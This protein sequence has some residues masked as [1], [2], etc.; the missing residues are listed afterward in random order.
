MHVSSRVAVAALATASLTLSLAPGALASSGGAGDRPQRPWHRNLTTDVLFPFQLAVHASHVWVADGATKTVSEVVDGHLVEVARGLPGKNSDVAGVAVSSDGTSLAYTSSNGSHSLTTLTIK[1]K[2]QPDV[3]ADLAAYE[4]SANPD[5]GVTYGLQGPSNPCARSFFR[6]VTGGP[7]TYS[8]AVDSHPYAVAS[9]GG[10]AWAVAD[11]G[12]N[13]VLRVS[14]TGEISTIAVLPAQ[15]STFTA[16]QVA[17]LGAPSCIVGETYAFEPV[18]T[19]VE[20]NAAGAM[21]VSSL[22]G[23]PEDASLGAR[24][25]VFSISGGVATKVAG[26]FLGATNLAVS[27]N[28]TLFVTEYFAGKVTKIRPNGDRSVYLKAANPVAIEVSNGYAYVGRTATFGPSGVTAP[29]SIDRYR[30][31][32]SD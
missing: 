22:P 1:T 11:A 7:A 21:W 15:K 30:L 3:V 32:L 2:G 5:A 18:A 24:G 6:M 8:G 12:G 10:G 14:A 28:G 25:S 19:D 16:A 13:D 26:N 29:G 9:L 31:P 23:G 27:G 4:A 20:V 17:A